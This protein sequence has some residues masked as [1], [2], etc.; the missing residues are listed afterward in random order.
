MDVEK[1]DARS[2]LSGGWPSS[3]T[4]ELSPEDRRRLRQQ[5]VE[6]SKPIAPFWP[7]R[8][9]IARNPLHGLEHLPFDEAVT[10]A[11]QLFGGKGYLSNDEYRRLYLEGRMTPAGLVRALHRVAP[12]LDAEP[13]VQMGSRR[14]EPVEVLRLHLLYGF[15]ELEP[16]M[17]AWR[18]S[19]E[20]A[21]SRFRGDVPQDTRRRVNE[22][23]LQE[24]RPAEQDPEEYYIA[25][26][27][28][29]ILSALN[30]VSPD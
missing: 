22:R 26:L 13:A 16:S 28:A 15:E 2:A 10:H 29:S 17:L 23:V 11:K 18:I 12:S 4:Q 27:W 7:M 21:T 14:I 24:R 1:R 30:L 5:I 9:F 20:E 25:T 6:A 8:T 19:Q 3:L